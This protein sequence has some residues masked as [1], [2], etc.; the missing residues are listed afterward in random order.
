METFPPGNA[1]W[2]DAS[3]LDAPDCTA[4]FPRA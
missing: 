4:Y 3:A 1:L 2:V